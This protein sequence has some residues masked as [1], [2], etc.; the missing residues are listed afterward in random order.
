LRNTV[1]SL[2]RAKHKKSVHYGLSFWPN[3]WN[4]K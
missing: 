1:Y 4:G 2:K 3:L